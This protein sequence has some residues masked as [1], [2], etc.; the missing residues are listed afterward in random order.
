MIKNKLFLLFFSVF[1]SLPII[2]NGQ[3]TKTVGSTIQITSETRTL[4]LK[5]F[6]SDVLLKP[7]KSSRLIVETEIQTT[8]NN[9]KILDYLC[10]AGR[11]DLLIF[12]DK[13]TN[14]ITI[15]ASK[16]QEALIVKG[17]EIEENITY[18]F[19][20]PTKLLDDIVLPDNVEL[21]TVDF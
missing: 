1:V 10:E 12:R 13:T 20:V 6:D 17:K 2:L 18:N 8:L 14:T 11:Y 9:P 5:I 21:S 16:N 19:Y 15:S 3:L 4:D 7:T